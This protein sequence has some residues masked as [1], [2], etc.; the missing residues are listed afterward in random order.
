MHNKESEP[1]S[2]R[3]KELQEL[4]KKIE[5][6]EKANKKLFEE[7]GISPHELHHLMN[8]KDNFSKTSWE[9]LQKQQQELETIL[10]RRIDEAQ[11]QIKRKPSPF[12]VKSGGH[13]IFVK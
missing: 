9:A 13:W 1:E 11:A 12:E 6:M 2:K 5:K 10:E 3:N 7:V 4:D 8:N